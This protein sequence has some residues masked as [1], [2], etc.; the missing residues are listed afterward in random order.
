LPETT[1]HLA[2]GHSPLQWW[3]VDYTGPLPRSEGARYALSCIDT[4]SGLIQAYPVLKA[5]QGYTIKA[6]TKLMAAYRTPQVIKSNQGTHFTGAMIQYWAEE[7]NIEWWFHLPYKLMGADLIEHYNGIHKG[8]LRTD[9][10]SLQEWAKRLYRTLQDLSERL[11]DCRPSALKML[12]TTWASPLRIQI[13]DSHWGRISSWTSLLCEAFPCESRIFWYKQAIFF[14]SF[15]A[16]LYFASPF[17]VT[18]LL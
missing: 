8:A 18:L 11:R 12:Q 2:R 14:L 10:Q 7:N 3:Q 13:M 5:N 4:A 16:P 15:I 17:I 6:L 1:A 9:F